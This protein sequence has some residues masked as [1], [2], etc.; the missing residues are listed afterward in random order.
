MDVFGVYSHG[1]LVPCFRRCYRVCNDNVKSVFIVFRHNEVNENN[2]Q[3]NLWSDDHSFACNFLQYIRNTYKENNAHT[4]SYD[5]IL[6]YID[7]HTHTTL[8]LVNRHEQDVGF[9]WFH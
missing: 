1:K 6:N 9:A 3:Q 2:S 7:E 4:E 8:T 5:T